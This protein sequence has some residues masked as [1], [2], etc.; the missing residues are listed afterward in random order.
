MFGDGEVESSLDCSNHETVELKMFTGVTKTNNYNTE[1]QKN[2]S[3]PGIRARAGSSSRI[4][5][6]EHENVPFQCAESQASM[7][8]GQQRWTGKTWISSNTKTKY[9]EGRSG[10]RLPRKNTRALPKHESMLLGKAELSWSWNKLGRWRATSRVSVCILA[11]K[12]SGRPQLSE[13]G[14][15]V[16]KDLEKVKVLNDLLF[17]VSIGQVCSQMS[18]SVGVKQYPQG[19]K[20]HT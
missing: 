19:R 4:T 9:R 7:V 14:K 16:T 3:C 2:F 1:L 6:S 12:G 10:V 8:E 13:A 17:S 5:S 20:C 18:H 15:L 11:A